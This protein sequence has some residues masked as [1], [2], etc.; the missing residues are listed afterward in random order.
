MIY[1]HRSVV[2]RLEHATNT[3]ENNDGNSIAAEK[4]DKG[5]QNGGN[6]GGQC[7]EEFSNCDFRNDF[8]L[9]QPVAYLG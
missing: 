5:E 6:E 7:I 3:N 1:I 4:G 9:Q 8:F 2:A